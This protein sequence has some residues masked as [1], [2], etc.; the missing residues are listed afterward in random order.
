MKKALIFTAILF[1]GMN[2]HAQKVQRDDKGNYVAVKY[3]REKEEDKETGKTF[4]DTKGNVFKVYESVSGKLYIRKT[5]KAGNE[6][7]QYLKIEG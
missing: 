6:Y 7:K 1:V 4:T 5:S 3:V 2:S